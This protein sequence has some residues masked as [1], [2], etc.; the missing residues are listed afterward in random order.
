MLPAP[1]INAPLWPSKVA[2][3]GLTNFIT[4]NAM[5]RSAIFST[6]VFRGQAARPRYLGKTPLACLG[7]MSVFQLAGEQLDQN[8]ADVFYELLRRAIAQGDASARE[9]R[10]QFN[11]TELLTA[12]GR[13][14][15]GKTLK[16]LNESLE[17]LTDATFYFEIP[18]L[19]TGRSRLILKAL[20]KEIHAQE[21]DYD[22]LIDVE[23]AK[24]FA[25]EQWAFLRK[26]ER[27]S[28]AGDPLAKGLH[29]YYA[30][31]KEPYP[32]LVDTLQGLM[33]RQTMQPSKF[34]K[35]LSASLAKL[36]AVTGWHTC[37]IANAGDDA[38][39]VRVIKKPP[40]AAK[41][42]VKAASSSRPAADHSIEAISWDAID[43]PLALIHLSV[44]QLVALMDG[45]A[46]SEWA[47]ILGT[48]NFRDEGIAWE[49]ARH[50]LERQ[51]VAL[52]AEQNPES[53]PYDI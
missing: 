43:T 21:C 10:V 51:C 53:D 49:A 46:K 14:R 27:D 48:R 8:D 11:R 24:L 33:G 42:P 17:R 38:A 7:S 45:Q 34:K 19:F 20:T 18:G 2:D 31:H 12:L 35:A 15:G 40:Q 36:K 32:V 39:K 50:I 1:T 30:T 52:L 26:K 22:V 37:E 4:P 28:L 41:K 23:L 29:A 5:A 9:A 16:L 3:K 13:A 6:Q 25:R 44:D 47:A